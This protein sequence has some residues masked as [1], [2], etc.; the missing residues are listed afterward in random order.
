MKTTDMQLAKRQVSKAL[1]ERRL[2][3]RKMFEA[4]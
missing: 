2:A 1:I 3:M 4:D